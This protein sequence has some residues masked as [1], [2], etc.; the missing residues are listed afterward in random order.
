[1][2]IGHD[3]YWHIKKNPNALWNC[4][5]QENCVDFYLAEPQ[6]SPEKH[7]WLTHS[8]QVEWGRMYIKTDHTK[9]TKAS[10]LSFSFFQGIILFSL[11]KYL[12]PTREGVNNISQI[13]GAEK[14]ITKKIRLFSSVKKASLLNPFCCFAMRPLL[15]IS[16]SWQRVE[17]LL[18]E[19]K[20][21]PVTHS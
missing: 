7:S 2:S 20:L 16:C 3:A 18:T 14:K 4:K 5:Y 17:K 6:T 1:M 15:H 13:M 11:G 21:K 8:M 19:Q 10:H 9:K 12:L